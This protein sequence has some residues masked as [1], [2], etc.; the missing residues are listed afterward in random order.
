[1]LKIFEM[2]RTYGKAV[3]RAAVAYGRQLKILSWYLHYINARVFSRAKAT[4]WTTKVST[5]EKEL[6]LLEIF[7]N[8]TLG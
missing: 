4:P 5:S 1:M 7:L 8:E 2:T 3:P 6:H